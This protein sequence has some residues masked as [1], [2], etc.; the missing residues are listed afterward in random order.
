MVQIV[1]LPHRAAVLCDA[2]LRTLYR[3]AVS[4]KNLLE[5][6]TAA[7]SA[8][9]LAGRTASRLMWSEMAAPPLTALG[10]ASVLAA[11]RPGALAPALP[12]LLVWFL[13]PEIA[14]FMSRPRRRRVERLTQQ[15][16]RRFRLLA[17]RTWLFFETFVGPD[18]QWLPPDHFQEDPRGEAARRTSPTN[19][20]LLLLATVSAYDLGYAGVLSVALRL[21]ETLDTLRRMERYRGHLYNWYDTANLQPLAPRYVSA[22]DSGNLAGCLL[23]VKQSGVELTTSPIIGAA[24]W[25]GMLDTLGVLDEVIAAASHRYGSSRFAALRGC[26]DKV[27]GQVAV[28]KDHPEDWARG[29]TRLVEEGCPEFDRALASVIAPQLEELD[30]RLLGELRAW[31]SRDPPAPRGHASRPPTPSSVDAAHGASACAVGG[32]RTDRAA[33]GDVGAAACLPARRCGAATGERDRRG[34][35]RVSLAA[36]RAAGG[37]AW[38]RQRRRGGACLGR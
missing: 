29:V 11:Y 33:R 34:R 19:I 8:R 6:T 10:A 35:T 12:F 38:R 36:R 28:L 20:G 2:L 30:A 26:V 7:L 14:L 27:R 22:V 9:R 21:K 18:D 17:R 25:E 1:F 37:N 13:S 3:L 24:R 4:R 15:D 32:R 23:A 5:W 16:T 31:Y